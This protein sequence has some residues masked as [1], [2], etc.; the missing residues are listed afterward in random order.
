MGIMALEAIGFA[1]KGKGPAFVLE[2]NTHK[3]GLIPTNLS[4]GFGH[5][6]GATGVRQVVDLHMQ[7]TQKAAQPS[8]PQQ[9][10][11]HDDQH[12]RQ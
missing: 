11:R 6:T 10:S 9:V 4:G 8:S 2:G 1:S 5:P 7:L 12:G 3:E